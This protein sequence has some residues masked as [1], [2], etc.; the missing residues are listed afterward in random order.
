MGQAG[1]AH[2]RR[3]VRARSEHGE[4]L[5]AET[6]RLYGSDWTGSPR[7]VRPRGR[8]ERSAEPETGAATA[9][10]IVGAAY[11][12]FLGDEFLKAAHATDI[13]FLGV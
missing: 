4:K 6:L 1:P 7:S 13:D 5:V 8:T 12:H 9:H 3:V 11:V 10:L 2:T